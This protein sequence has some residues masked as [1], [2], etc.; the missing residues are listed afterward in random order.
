M[1]LRPAASARRDRPLQPR[2]ALPLRRRQ[3]AAV[4]RIRPPDSGGDDTPP[5]FAVVVE[6]ISRCATP[7]HP[8]R[9][10]GALPPAV[11]TVAGSHLVCIDGRI[12]LQRRQPPPVSAPTT[13][14]LEGIEILNLV[15][16]DDRA[17]EA[18]R[19]QQFAA[20]PEQTGLA[21]LPLR[22]QRLDGE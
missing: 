11:R 13:P 2:R 9:R 7:R 10:R 6:D 3:H 5:S 17:M 16:P 19:L 20:N 21:P 4:P 8:P 12:H 18:A 14:A 1:A 22:Y 15:H